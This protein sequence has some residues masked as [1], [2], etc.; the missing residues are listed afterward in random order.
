MQ[1]AECMAQSDIPARD[2]AYTRN[3]F[4]N[5]YA[6]RGYGMID[7]AAPRASIAQI[8][9]GI[10]AKKR[11]ARITIV[12]GD[13]FDT[14]PEEEKHVVDS[15]KTGSGIALG[16]QLAIP[17]DKVQDMMV[18]HDQL[19]ALMA[20]CHNAVEVVGIGSGQVMA[21]V[22]NEDMGIEQAIDMYHTSLAGSKETQSDA[23]GI[24]RVTGDI[25][26]AIQVAP[27]IMEKIQADEQDDATIIHS[28]NFLSANDD[29]QTVIGELYI[30]GADIDW[31]KVHPDGSGQ[32]T[33]LPTY[34]FE[35]KN[36]WMKEN[37]L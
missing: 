37:G 33:R 23:H 12:I 7:T 9:K 20:I 11:Q 22:L 31:D 21:H 27:D 28:H 29:S 5:H 14:S 15:M 17:K 13:M 8:K 10:Y 16:K 6:Y 36:I 4:R 18:V 1:T 34:P 19:H 26:L 32:I 2:L 25:V 3:R 35:R 30:H 24:G